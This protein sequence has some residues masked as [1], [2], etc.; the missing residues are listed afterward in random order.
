MLKSNGFIRAQQI[1]IW[2]KCGSEFQ[3]VSMS[4]NTV[5]T[6]LEPGFQ[7][8]AEIMKR[9]GNLWSMKGMMVNEKL[10]SGEGSRTWTDNLGVSLD[11]SPY[12]HPSAH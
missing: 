9:E 7:R 5:K 10:I 11:H 8:A 12:P 4:H 3:S 1:N 6:N 2:Q